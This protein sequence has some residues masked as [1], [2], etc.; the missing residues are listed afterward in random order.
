[1]GAL[2]QQQQPQQP[3]ETGAPDVSQQLEPSNVEL[4][5]EET[6]NISQLIELDL[7]GDKD[8]KKNDDDS[9]EEVRL[10]NTLVLVRFCWFFT[11]FV[12]Y[13]LRESSELIDI[14]S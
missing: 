7:L 1:M 5:P 2:D 9:D 3:Q 10:Y 8:K 11:S 14:D 6:T 4:P 12:I 13:L